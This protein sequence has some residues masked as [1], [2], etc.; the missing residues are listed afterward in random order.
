MSLTAA[1]RRL[2]RE[3][4]LYAAATV[5]FGMAS[6]IF[7]STFNNFLDDRFMLSGFV[8][9]FLEFPREMPGFLTVFFSAAL[10]FL[11]SRRM[12]AVAMLSCALGAALLGFYSPTYII[13][14]FWLF[15]YSLGQHLFL[16]LQQFIGMELAEKGKEG[17]RLGQLNSLRNVAIILGSLLVF[18][19]FRYLNFNFS[20]TFVLTSVSMVLAALML[21][22][23]KPARST[24]RP[25]FLRLHREYSLYY[26]LAIL[27]GSRKQIFITFAP[28]VIV[29]VFNQP[30]QTLATLMTIGG[31]IGVLFQPILGKAIDRLGE[32]TV[33]CMEAILLML[34]CLGYGFVKF[35]F[36][37]AVAFL[38]T[39]IF[40]LLDQILMSVNMARATYMKKIARYPEDIQPALTASVTIDH[41]FSIA[42]A[43]LGGLIWNQ[44]GFQYVFLLGM[45]IAAINLMAALRIRLP[46]AEAAPSLEAAKAGSPD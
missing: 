37:E 9:S 40:Y 44:F 30:T 46:L 27:Y 32:K 2:P 8:R 35:I 26:V 41:I 20:T 7:D 29:T 14:V 39:C 18:V 34:V 45:G 33:I 24:K 22:A 5:F 6:S 42:V 12:A 21:F 28:W 16:P 17:E 19:G 3:L 38:L 31:V 15:F 36:P 11:P 13:M 10:W 4:W 43:L 1:L 25:V 23:M